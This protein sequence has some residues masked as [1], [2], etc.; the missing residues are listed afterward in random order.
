MSTTQL[1][2]DEMIDSVGGGV[3][4]TIEELCEEF[5]IVFD[6]LIPREH[7]YIDERIFCCDRCN[8]TMPCDELADSEEADGFICRECDDE[9]EHEEED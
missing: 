9:G 7:A 5:N 2:M 6:D 8:W 3:C 4:K 1:R